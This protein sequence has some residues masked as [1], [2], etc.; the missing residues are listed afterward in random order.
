MD[1]ASG[2]AGRSLSSL[3]HLEQRAGVSPIPRLALAVEQA[4][5]AKAPIGTDRLESKLTCE[6]L[7]KTC[8]TLA[9]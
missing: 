8:T 1:S 4:L 7:G 3:G 9:R 5:A 2:F 6:W